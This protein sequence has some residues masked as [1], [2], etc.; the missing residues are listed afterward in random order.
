MSRSR[1][2]AYSRVR[3]FHYKRPSFVRQRVDRIFLCRLDS[4]IQCANDR[5]ENGNEGRPQNPTTRDYDPESLTT[6]DS[7]A[8]CQTENDA[9]DD[10]AN[11]QQHG[12]AENHID[13]VELRSA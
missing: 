12:L 8:G 1:T 7:S 11:G 13:N 5:S 9:D 4:G 10:A 3:A 6:I 2:F